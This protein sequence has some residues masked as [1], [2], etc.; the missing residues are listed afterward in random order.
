MVLPGCRDICVHLAVFPSGLDELIVAEP[1]S[2]FTLRGFSGIRSVHEVELSRDTAI[3]PDGSRVGL[4]RLCLSDQLAADGYGLRPFE[5]HRADRAAGHETD[6]VGKERLVPMLSVVLLEHLA[7]KLAK[8]E[9]CDLEPLCLETT[10]DFAYQASLDA[11]YLHKNE[12][13]FHENANF[14]NSGRS[15]F[16]SPT[17]GIAEA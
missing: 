17:T 7:G 2:Y 15:G 4:S 6:H 8:L 16:W 11:I 14:R 13:T 3:S 10:E 9:T 1:E 12:R 5:D